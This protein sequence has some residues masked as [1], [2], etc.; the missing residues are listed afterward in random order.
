[1]GDEAGAKETEFADWVRQVNECVPAVD[2][3]VGELMAALKETGQLSNTL[4]IYTADQGYAMG[5]HGLRMKIAPYDASYRSPL[6]VSMPGAVA[7]GGTCPQSPNAPDLVA[8][9]FKLAGVEL[10]EG[11]HGRDLTPLFKEPAANWLYPCLYEHTGH[12]FGDDVARILRD[13]PQAAT[14][15]KVPWY[16]A[17]VER[18][19]KYIRYLQPGVPEELYDLDSDPGELNNLFGDERHAQQ[20]DRLREALAAEL[21]RTNAPAEILSADR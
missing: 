15:Q 19:L 1:V 21:K 17:V 3:G 7:A 9:I 2:E 6:I 12:D 20:L 11:L 16:T 18:G 14:Y 5:E 4:V 10:P 13:D 8:T